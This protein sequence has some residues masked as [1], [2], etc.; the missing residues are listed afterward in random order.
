MQKYLQIMLAF[1][2]LLLCAAGQ[3]RHSSPRTFLR[4]H[5]YTSMGRRWP[6]GYPHFV[7]G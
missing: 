6:I 7:G 5:R 3:H 4:Q 1:F 2:V